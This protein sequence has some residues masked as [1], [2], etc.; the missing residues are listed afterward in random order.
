MAASRRVSGFGT[1]IFTEMTRLANEHGAVNLAQGFPDFDAPD[2][3]KDAAKRAIDAAHNQYAPMAGLPALATR[4]ADDHARRTGISRDPASEVLIGCGA[5]ELLFDAVIALTDPGDEVVLLEPFY[6]SYLAA[7]RIAGA[8][9]KVVTLAPPSFE[10]DAEA[11]E[12]VVTERTRLIIVNQ[13]HNPSGR[14]FTRRELDIVAGVA[15]RHDLVCLADEVYERLVY[16]G[17]HLSISTLPGMAERTLTFGS[18]SKTYSVTGWRVGWA[19]GPVALV[20]ATR[21]AHQY[22][23]FTAP[24][25]LQHGACAALDAPSDY[26]A[27]LLA[28]YRARRDFLVDGLRD[29]GLEPFR[30]EGAYF[31]CAGFSK[32]PFDDDVAFAR[33]L[34]TEIG[35][36][37]IPPSSFHLT[38]GEGRTYVRFTFA[39]QLPTLER[40]RERLR[41]LADPRTR[42]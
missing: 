29:A 27:T 14:V 18:M 39:K 42:R 33:Y 1:T 6:D 7:V 9:P 34:T 4:I 31:V 2:F 35:V 40:A 28:E 24:A 16:D 10:I 23:T 21:A 8:T 36:A 20:A 15:R 12:R 25:P 17:E 3:V 37:A 41:R 19:I 13:P 32:F 30:C 26:Y 11:I 22:V 5:T 38:P